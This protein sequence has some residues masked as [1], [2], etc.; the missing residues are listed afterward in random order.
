[1]ESYNISLPLIKCQSWNSK[2]WS[3]LFIS[4]ANAMSWGFWLIN[5]FFDGTDSAVI[6]LHCFFLQ[7]RFM[8]GN[9]II[10]LYDKLQETFHDT[11]ARHSNKHTNGS[12]NLWED[13]DKWVFILIFNDFNLKWIIMDS[14]NKHLKTRHLLKK[15]YILPTSVFSNWIARLA[16]WGICGWPCLGGGSGILDGLI[17]L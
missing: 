9:D 6:N 4:V 14:K 1:M 11:H 10:G 3:L 8:F 2:T 12:P 13:T 5:K 17:K 15:P 16:S 7:L